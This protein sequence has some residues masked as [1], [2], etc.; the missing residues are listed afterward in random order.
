[1]SLRDRLASPWLTGSLTV[2]AIVL[3]AA[4]A[5]ATGLVTIPNVDL[6]FF[7]IQGPA[8][9]S[10]AAPLPTPTPSPA[11]PTFLRPTPSPEPTFVAYTVQVGD[12]LNS[13][14][15]RYQTTARSIAWWNRGR[16]PSLDPESPAYKPNRIELGW[17]LVVL[18]GQV[19]D[20]LNPPTPSPAPETPVAS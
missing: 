3:A 2:A 13:I 19:V 1:M 11:E 17:V 8:A 6:S 4:A 15:T 18:P 14:A 20:E 12:S 16:Y 9:T 10:N 5:V 7:T